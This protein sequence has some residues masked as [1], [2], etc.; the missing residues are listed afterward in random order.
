MAEGIL[1]R[2]SKAEEKIERMEELLGCREVVERQG[3]KLKGSGRP[4]VLYR[5]KSIVEWADEYGVHWASIYRWKKKM[6]I[7]R[8]ISIAKALHEKRSEGE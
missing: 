2:P 3:R 5:G 7:K 8:A 6:G 4:K 1:E